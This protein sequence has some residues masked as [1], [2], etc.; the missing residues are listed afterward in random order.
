MKRKRLFLSLLS[1]MAILLASIVGYGQNDEF[2][3]KK[4]KDNLYLIGDSVNG[5]VS[6]L[7]TE[8]GVLC[9]DAKS[10][11]Y[12]GEKVVEMIRRVTDKPIKYLVY[13]HGHSD[14]IQG[15]QSFPPSTIVI[16]HQKT[17]ELMQK[18]G[19]ARIERERKVEFPRQLK[20][21]EDKVET[22]KDEGVPEWKEAERTLEF[23]RFQIKDHDRLDL[24]FP[25]LTFDDRVE[26][27]LGGHRI[28]LTYLGSGHTEGDIVVYFLEEK[29]IHTGDLFGYPGEE[30]E[31]VKIL[32]VKNRLEKMEPAQIKAMAQSIENVAGILEKILDMDFEIA[33]PGHG[34]ISDKK[35]MLIQKEFT[36]RLAKEILAGAEKRS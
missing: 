36:K 2:T 15:A 31:R 23:R 8:E 29:V 5:N 33:I 6:F 26:V 10:Y 28:E 35:G 25:D 20:A 32:D 34:K 3:L 24:I 4:V 30:E 12:Q 11:P 22:L 19:A 14:H 9:V 18:D 21:L 16:A 13:T 1:V 17:L 27:H 7:V